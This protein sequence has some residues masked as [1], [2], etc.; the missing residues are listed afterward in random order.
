MLG[1]RGGRVKPPRTGW[2]DAVV[3][4][5]SRGLQRAEKGLELPLLHSNFHAWKFDVSAQRFMGKGFTTAM[6]FKLHPKPENRKT[7]QF[8]C[9]TGLAGEAVGRPESAGDVDGDGSDVEQADARA[10]RPRPR[11][12]GASGDSSEIMIGS[13]WS[14]A[15]RSCSMTADADARALRACAS[16]AQFESPPRP[17]GAT[18]QL[19]PGVLLGTV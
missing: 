16:R 7:V 9:K 3:A 14:A 13:P 17:A 2:N 15:T 1:W 6:P 19:L 18:G 10:E 4:R 12:D 8:E 5:A 11:R